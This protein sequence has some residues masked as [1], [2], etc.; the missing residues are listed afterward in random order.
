MEDED[1]EIFTSIMNTN[2]NPI[3]N[4]G[5]EFESDENDIVDVDEQLLKWEEFA[6]IV[7]EHF[8]S[9][10]RFNRNPKRTVENTIN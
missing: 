6:I 5:I 7:E 10:E 3:P 2:H 9:L 4:D 1:E 8:I